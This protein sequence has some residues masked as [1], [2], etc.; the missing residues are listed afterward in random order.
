MTKKLPLKAVIK[1]IGTN[2]I[3]GITKSW[4]SDT[5][6]DLSGNFFKNSLHCFRK[7]RETGEG[8]EQCFYF[9]KSSKVKQ[10]KI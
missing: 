7:D 4:L 8:E 2:C 3:Y 6:S 1:D 9:K 10:E 5:D